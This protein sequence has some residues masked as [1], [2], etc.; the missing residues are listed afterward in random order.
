MSNDTPIQDS[1]PDAP[2]ASKPARSTFVTVIAWVFICLGAAFA[3]ISGAEL[4]GVLLLSEKTIQTAVHNSDALAHMPAYNRFFIDHI[5]LTL[6]VSLIALLLLFV[7]AIGLLK[8]KGW[9]RPTMI[10]LLGLAVI[11]YVVAV[12]MQLLYFS[13][14]SIPAPPNASA[15]E[16]ATYQSMMSVAMYGSAIFSLAIAAVF[17]W[18]I[19]RL[20]SPAIRAEFGSAPPDAQSARA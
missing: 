14:A 4:V 8:R 19:V 16:A 17:V 12:T 2:A 1:A 20:M 18:I 13:P 5:G 3:L 6:A 7:T 10:A 9:A 15:T 11:R